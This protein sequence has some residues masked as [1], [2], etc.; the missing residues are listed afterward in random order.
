MI[1]TNSG[2][3]WIFVLTGVPNCIFS[4]YYYA[5]AHGSVSTGSFSVNNENVNSISGSFATD[6]IENTN[7]GKID[8]IAVTNGTISFESSGTS[9]YRGLAALQVVRAL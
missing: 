3:N 1:F 7:W 9:G 6:L 8:N 2:A 4:I 5:P